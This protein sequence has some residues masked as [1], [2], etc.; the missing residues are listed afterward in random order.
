M[1]ITERSIRGGTVLMLSGE[2]NFTGRRTFNDAVK[3][4]WAANCPHLLVNLEGVAFLDSAALG[5]L[6]IANQACQEKQCRM[7]LIKPQPYVAEVLKLANIQKMIP[8]HANEEEALKM[9]VR[10]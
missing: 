7:S 5:L 1:H 9:V 2:F 6:A 4:A 8:I 10:A 3:K